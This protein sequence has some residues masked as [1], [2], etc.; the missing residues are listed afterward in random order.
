MRIDQNT[1][2]GLKALVGTMAVVLVLLFLPT[3]IFAIKK[4]PVGVAI[5]LTII[6]MLF[7]GIVVMGAMLAGAAWTRKNMMDGARMAMAS[8]DFNDRWD[9]AKMNN[10][11]KL[12]TEGARAAGRLK[13]PAPEETLALPLPSQG[14]DWLPSV[15]MF[16]DDEVIEGE[17]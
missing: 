15:T 9:V 1:V 8:Q 12:F 6:G 2:D 17:W 11:T 14:M 5:S 16:Q 4:D 10:M 7:L 13:P 3:I